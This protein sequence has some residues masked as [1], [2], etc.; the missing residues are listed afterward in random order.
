MLESPE[1]AFILLAAGA[2]TRMGRAKQMLDVGG[3]S[4]LRHVI[5]ATVVAPVRPY[6]VVLGAE[7]EVI[8]AR[9]SDAPVHLVVNEA[10]SE[11]IASSIRAG[12]AAV[13]QRAPDVGGVIIA[14]GDQPGLDEP[15][16]GALLRGHELLERG[17]VS[18]IFQGT[19]QPPVYFSSD[20]FPDLMALRGDT[21][22][23][24]LVKKHAADAESLPMEDLWDIDTAE[25]YDAFVKSGS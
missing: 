23:K 1:C 24:Y 18:A 8:Q 10:W 5:D 25:D 14:L 4:M 17:I 6:V 9:L 3:K 15:K 22:A 13:L 11:G 21:G 20:Y 7:A 2:S 12:L 16:I 19:A